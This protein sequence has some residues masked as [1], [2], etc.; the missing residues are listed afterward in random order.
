MNRRAFVAGLGAVL[1]APLGAGAQASKVYQIGYLDLA[2]ASDGQSDLEAFTQ[3]L[4]DLGYAEGRNVSINSRWADGNR[5]RLT[6]LAAELVELKVDA[7]VTITTPAAQ[8]AKAATATIPIVMAGAF[9]PVKLGLVTSLA[10]PGGNVT[11]MTNSTGP[12]HAGKN[13]QLITEASPRVSRVA[14]LWNP[15]IEPEM[16]GSSS[17]RR[18]YERRGGRSY[19]SKSPVRTRSTL[20]R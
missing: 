18:R 9:E 3:R 2:R 10:R 13:L 6:S 4:R 12:E 14:W 17:L 1:A 11:G 15:M 19:P 7:I 8:A 20:M 16:L 5:D